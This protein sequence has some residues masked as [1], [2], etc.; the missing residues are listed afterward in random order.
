M[1]TPKGIAARAILELSDGKKIHIEIRDG[2]MFV[3]FYAICTVRGTG[4]WRTVERE[5]FRDKNYAT[6]IEEAAEKLEQRI[7]TFG[8]TKVNRK[9]IRIYRKRLYAK[10]FQMRPDELGLV[11]VDN[12]LHYYMKKLRPSPAIFIQKK[13]AALVESGF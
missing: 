11:R 12:L 13:E 9:T 7:N 10:R 8:R 5:S 4:R 3:Q 6:S 1:T 2:S